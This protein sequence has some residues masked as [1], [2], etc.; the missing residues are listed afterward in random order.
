MTY[1]VDT[2][3]ARSDK[4]KS[5]L[6]GLTE[7]KEKLVVQY[8]P[9]VKYVVGRMAI[10]LPPGMDNDDL[11]SIGCWGLI[12]AA[13]KFDHSRGVQFKTYAMTRIR[14]SI[15]DEL[16][17]LS[18]GGQALCRKAQMLE[19]AFARVEAAKTRPATTEEVAADLEMTK[20]EVEK[21]I[22]EV[23]MSFM[24]SLDNHYNSEDDGESKAAS[25]ADTNAPEVDFDIQLTERKEQLEKALDSLQDQERLVISLYY[26]EELTLKE[27]A[28]IVK[29][30]ESRISQIHGKAI[31][32]L[33][34]KLKRSDLL[35]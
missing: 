33:K 23:N 22:A 4:S 15:L 17:R 10:N 26:Y 31:F 27:I 30:S 11:I 32:Q 12:D 8:V 13:K 9:L 24:V 1:L 14:G 18:L 7:D 5:N 35:D 21:M 19:K 25:I 16:R 20:D 3:N 28:K 2:Y 29:V 34:N 6:E